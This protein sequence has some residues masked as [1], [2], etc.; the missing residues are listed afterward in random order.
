MK[1]KWPPWPSKWRPGAAKV[2]QKAP[3]GPQREREGSQKDAKREPWDDQKASKYR[4][5]KFIRKMEPYFQF[6]DTFCEPFWESNYIKNLVKIRYGISCL[7]LLI[8][9]EKSGRTNPLNKKE[10]E[11]KITKKSCFPKKVHARKPLYSCS[12]MRVAEVCP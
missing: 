1:P 7:K 12:R 6:Y 5:S 9:S 2:N 10:F 3:K 11:N 8:K 4:C